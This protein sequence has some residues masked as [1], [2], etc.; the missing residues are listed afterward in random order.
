MQLCLICSFVLV[1]TG[2]LGAALGE[3]LRLLHSFAYGDFAKLLI[4]LIYCSCMICNIILID[5]SCLTDDIVLIY[6]SCLLDGAN[7]KLQVRPVAPPLPV[8]E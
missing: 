6:C 1:G 2:G 3:I 7:E 5:C 4:Y 8:M